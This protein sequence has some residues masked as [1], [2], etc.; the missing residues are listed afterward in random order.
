MFQRF[1]RFTMKCQNPAKKFSTATQNNFKVCVIGSAGGIGQPLCL[2]L[3]QELM[4]TYLNLYDIAKVNPGVN[5]DLS[6]VNTTPIVQAFTGCNVVVITA[7]MPR[8]P[9][10][11][12]EDL[13][14]ANAAVVYGF[15]CAVACF[16]PC[17]L[18]AIVTN[19]LNSMVPVFS[20]VLMR[21][22]CYDPCKIFGVTTLDLV[23]ASTFAGQ[24]S[25]ADPSYL[26]I[27]V[28]G[29]HAGKTIVP[30][31]SQ[32]RP[33]LPSMTQ[34]DIQKLT[35][36]IQEAGTEVVKAKAGEGSATLSMAFAAARFVRSLL[37]GLSGE[38]VIECAYVRSCATDAA[39][40]AN[41]L[42]L[43][44]YGIERNLGY[45]KLN[46][47]EGKQLQE[48]VPI[49]VKNIEDGVKYVIQKA[50]IKP[51]TKCEPPKP[52]SKTKG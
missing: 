5:V 3:K 18:V 20:E 4:I 34:E 33:P 47:Y 6:H 8:K 27:P 45:G 1:L 43:G 14:G 9:G 23:R 21:C 50:D 41:P 39:Y 7:G 13:F 11:S 2:L 12:R 24:I 22:G 36:R 42:V 37:K 29:G 15:A 26:D 32:S 48:A 46:A 51:P 44:R 52:P 40:F 31:L 17:A 35:V 38:P 10:M 16:S 30:L 49:L 25:C 28:I 19:P